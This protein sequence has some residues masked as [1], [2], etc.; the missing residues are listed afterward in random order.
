VTLN[1][2]ERRNALSLGV[3]AQL[4][5]VFTDHSQAPDVRLA[6]VRGAGDKA[7]ASG[8]DLVELDSIRS[9]AETRAMSE[10]GK[11]AL[12]AIR[13]FPV[14]VVAALNGLALG[15]GSE[16]ALACD[17]RFA[18]DSAT[19]GMI[20]A[21]LSI[22][23][24][25]GGG[26]DVMRLVGYARGLRLLTTGQVLTAREAFAA[27]L[28]DGV[29]PPG[30][31][32]DTALAAFIA[33]MQRPAQVMRALKSL[34]LGE[35]MRDRAQLEDAETEHFTKVWTHPDHWAAVEAVTG[36]AKSNDSK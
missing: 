31:D 24:S 2:P 22:A 36:K 5:E 3:L 7:F 11:R 18:A 28:V 34:S 13:R 10:H 6:I 15:G 1:R 12:N 17:M 25:W 30:A 9:A 4:G 19:I 27:G 16:L 8:G 21:R 20:H 26:V 35:R 23:P 33:G 32:F 14:P 29:A